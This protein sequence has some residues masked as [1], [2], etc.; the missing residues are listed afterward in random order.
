MSMSLGT[1]DGYFE[2]YNGV[3]VIKSFLTPS[4]NG[5]ILFEKID[6]LGGQN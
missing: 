2:A 5:R 4:A 6:I 3:P 1:K